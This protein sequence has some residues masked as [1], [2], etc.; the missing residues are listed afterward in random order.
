MMGSTTSSSEDREKRKQSKA[1]RVIGG[2][3]VLVFWLLVWHLI[4]AGVGLRDVYKRQ[5]VASQVREMLAAVRRD[6]GPVLCLSLIH[7]SRKAPAG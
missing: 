1:R 7:I 6:F 3:L 4:A 5:A 2:A